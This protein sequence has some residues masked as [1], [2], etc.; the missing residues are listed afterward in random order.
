MFF[1]KFGTMDFER[2]LREEHK[3]KP[4]WKK[5]VFIQSWKFQFRPEMYQ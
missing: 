2:I 5:T 3:Q 1:G 4:G